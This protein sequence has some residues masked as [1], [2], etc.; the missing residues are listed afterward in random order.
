MITGTL[1]AFALLFGY[2]VTVGLSL[3][4][5][6]GIAAARP[7]WVAENYRLKS[8]YKF[9]QGLLWLV[10]VTAGAYATAAVAGVH[11]WIVGT[12]L[13]GILIGVLWTNVWE[14]RQRGLGHQVLISLFSLAGVGA[15]YVLRLR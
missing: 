1:I 10:C 3:V 11:P 8:G 2:V 7:G 6:L 14:A 5:T 4:A 13:A 9:L 15:G 12:V